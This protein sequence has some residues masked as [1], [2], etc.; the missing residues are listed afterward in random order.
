[1]IKK[2]HLRNSCVIIAFCATIIL[3]GCMSKDNDTISYGE[4]IIAIG[5][6]EI[7]VDIAKTAVDRA[8]GLS[9]R[10]AICETCGMLFVFDDMG[11]RHFWMKEMLFDIDVVWIVDDRIIGLAEHVSHSAQDRSVFASPG[12]VNRVVE[13]PSGYIAD[14]GISVGQKVTYIDGVFE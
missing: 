6:N 11:M 8:R 14:H 12:P 1:M 9:G 3:S 13:L 7:T 5:E 10:D 4:G 2:I